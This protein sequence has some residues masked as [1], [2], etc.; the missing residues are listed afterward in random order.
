M[1]QPRDDR[2]I[3]VLDGREAGLDHPDCGQQVWHQQRVDDEA[4]P[5]RAVHHLLA[6]HRA[7][8]LLGPLQSRI[9]S[10]QCADELNQRQHRDRVEE[11]KA[12][13][14]ARILRRRS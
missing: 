9:R 12:Q 3:D 10:H 6:Q 5:V 1:R 11:V 4:R 14:S 7:G 2:L 13:Y 8:E